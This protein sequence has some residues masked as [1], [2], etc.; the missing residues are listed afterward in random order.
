MPKIFDNDTREDIRGQMLDNGFTLIKRFGLKKTTIED[1]TRSSGV[2][3][4][5]FYNF[6]K[7]KE[8][9]IYQIV[10][11]K[12]RAVREHYQEIIRKNG[13]AVDRALLGDM[14]RFIINGD[15]N[16]LT[17]L[18]RDDLAMLAARWPKEYL[19]NA[20]NDDKLFAWLLDKVAER[21]DGCDCRVFSNLFNVIVIGLADQ[22]KLH[23][24]ALEPTV[25][26][27]VESLLDYVFEPSGAYGEP[28]PLHCDAREKSPA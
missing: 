27:C 22:N 18:S 14:I 24:D 8:E 6:F 3:K 11:F 21:R 25:T 28:Q 5:T 4:G 12:R 23:R 26:H 13:G 10:I 2:A 1:V 9:F 15:Y 19:A 7:T 20:E 17:Y 16:L